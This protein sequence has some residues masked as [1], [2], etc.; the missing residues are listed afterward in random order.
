MAARVSTR[1]LV[2][3]A[4]LVLSL[5]WASQWW[6]GRSEAQI[7]AQVAALAKPGDIRMIS[8]TTCPICKVAKAWYGEHQVA[9]AECVIEQ[10]AACRAEYETLGTPGTPVMLVRGKPQLGFNPARLLAALQGGG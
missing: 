4:V 2:G 1:S 10:D 9:H 3:L 6:A 7:G 5:T 8:S